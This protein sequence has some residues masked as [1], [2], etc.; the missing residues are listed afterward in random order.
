MKKLLRFS[1]GIR[2]GKKTKIF[3]VFSNHSNDLL[4]IIHWRSGW[5]CYVMS[6]EG[7]ID[8]SL[9]C[10][11]ELN[12]FMEELE[13]QRKLNLL[14]AP[15]VVCQKKEEVDSG[16]CEDCLKDAIKNLKEKNISSPKAKAM[17]IRNGRTI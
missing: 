3:S 2:D 10:N 11:K 6:Y 13:K 15:C 16:M 4:G 12:I 7:G 8:M 5:R 9:S 1:E 17:G 14:D